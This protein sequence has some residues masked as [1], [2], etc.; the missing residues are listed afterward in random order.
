MDY[1]LDNASMI[2]NIFNRLFGNKLRENMNCSSQRLNKILETGRHGAAVSDK[3]ASALA[4][5]PET[6]TERVYGL[7]SL[8]RAHELGNNQAGD[9]FRYNL[10]EYADKK[11]G[12]DWRI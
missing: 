4:R 1:L 6:I 5:K 10:I 12:F 8:R 11:R 3:E 2:F 7:Y 9:A